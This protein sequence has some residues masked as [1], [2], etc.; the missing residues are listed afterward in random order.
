M[1]SFEVKFYPSDPSQLLEEQSRCVV[2]V[3]A[4]TI[5]MNQTDKAG[6][7][8]HLVTGPPNVPILFCSLASV[9][10]YRGL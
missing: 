7:I 5:C 9:I 4:S 10:V 3:S 1:L 2:L 6:Y 8:F